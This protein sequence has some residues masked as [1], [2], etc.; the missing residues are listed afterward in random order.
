VGTLRDWFMGTKIDALPVKATSYETVNP[1]PLITVTSTGQ[2]ITIDLSELIGATPAQ[3]FRTQPYLRSVVSFLARN[4]AQLGLHTYR[5]VND[6]NRERES[7]SVTAQLIRK[8]NDYTT[9]YELLDALVSDLALWDQA[10]WWISPDNKLASG[11]RITYL[12]VA[13]VDV[14][15]GGDYFEPDTWRVGVLRTPDSRGGSERVHTDLIRQRPP[16]DGS[17]VEWLARMQIRG[18]T[19]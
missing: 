19:F 8:P 6:L 18:G 3:M 16:Y 5:K 17:H 1:N 14:P 11:W 2:E 4:I 15:W 10:F 7:D 12:P 9:R 13:W